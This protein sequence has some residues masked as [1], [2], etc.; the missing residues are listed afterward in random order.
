MLH[1]AAF[2]FDMRH[3]IVPTPCCHISVFL[4][5]LK[6]SCDIS[7][8]CQW[9]G[10]VVPMNLVPVSDI[11]LLKRCS[12][13]YNFK[14]SEAILWLMLRQFPDVSLRPRLLYACVCACSIKEPKQHVN[15]SEP[16]LT[17]LIVSR[18][19]WCLSLLVAFCFWL[20]FVVF[21]SV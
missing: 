19:S 20:L 21:G 10:I 3:N 6:E 16:T 8:I 18:V 12:E 9:C 14:H 4:L 13:E 5:I 2:L 1:S 11:Q 15:I 17:W 7:V